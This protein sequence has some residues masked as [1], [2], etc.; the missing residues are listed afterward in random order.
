M[1]QQLFPNGDAEKFCSHIFRAFNADSNGVIDFT[2]FLMAINITAKGDP[3]KK[4]KWAFKMY[5]VDGNGEID[6][7]EMLNIIQVNNIYL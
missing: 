4:L 6:K 3:E 1:Y 2:E 7:T 5:D